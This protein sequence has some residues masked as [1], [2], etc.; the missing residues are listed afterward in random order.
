MKIFKVKTSFL[1][2]I[3]SVTL[4]S[5]NTKTSAQSE[6]KSMQRGKKVYTNNC[7]VCH[8]SNGQGISKIFPPLATSDYLMEDISRAGAIILKGKNGVINVNGVNYK[9][10]MAGF[11][12][13]DQELADV[14]NYISNSWGNTTKEVDVK[15]ASYVRKVVH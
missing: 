12:L 1:L 15:W 8:M 11:P 5:W 13:S 9:G 2:L 3:V 7:V 4:V 6:S 10:M 14:V